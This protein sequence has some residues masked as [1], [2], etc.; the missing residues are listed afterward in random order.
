MLTLAES[1][2]HY[3]VTPAMVD[4]L[5]DLTQAQSK[6][7]SWFQYRAGRIT[8]SRFRQVLHTNPHEPSLS[9][10]KSI[11]YSEI[12]K[13]S[14]NATIWG[15]EHEKDALQAYKVQMLTSHEELIVTFTGFFISIEHPFLG[16][17]PDAIVKC[18]WCGLG[19][20][21]VKCPLC[22]HE[23][24][25]EEVVGA[26]KFCLEKQHDGKYQLKHDNAYYYQCQLQLF[27]TGRS[28]CD[29]VVWTKDELHIER[30]TLDEA[31]IESALPIAEKFYKL[32]I[33]PE[34]LGKWYT[35][36]QSPRDSS[37]QPP[38]DPPLQI[39][40]DDGTWCHCKERKGGDMVACDN[41]SCTTTWLH[42]E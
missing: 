25:I 5:V 37:V 42:L 35:R 29:F 36:K 19:V 24:S 41:K 8:A 30:I 13:F 26:G 17:S 32:C 20:V 31:L 38:R 18:D 40:E 15:C 21:E 4:H 10:L 6:S 1:H 33:L 22:A 11:F 27:V 2:L 23:S 34:L 39:E 14:T 16:A 12:H 9:L 3:K 7:K 28:F